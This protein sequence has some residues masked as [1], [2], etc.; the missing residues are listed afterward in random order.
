M[1]G[2]G[3]IVRETLRNVY[4]AQLTSQKLLLVATRFGS[5][6]SLVR[7]ILEAGSKCD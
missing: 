2:F 5:R 7:D 6:G 4:N 3:H 1:S